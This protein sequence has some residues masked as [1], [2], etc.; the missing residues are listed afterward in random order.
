MPQYIILI[1]LGLCPLWP[2]FWS[3]GMEIWELLTSST[4]EICVWQHYWGWVLLVGISTV[5]VG[6]QFLHPFFYGIVIEYFWSLEQRAQYLTSP[7]DHYSPNIC[8]QGNHFWGTILL[9]YQLPGQMQSVSRC[10]HEL[11]MFLSMGFSYT[12][13]PLSWSQQCSCLLPAD[14]CTWLFPQTY[15]SSLPHWVLR[16]ADLTV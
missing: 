12:F 9:P 15:V 6:S 4:Q 16:T 10:Q 14:E 13:P 7:T 2:S 11:I 3:L 8:N 5:L 1:R